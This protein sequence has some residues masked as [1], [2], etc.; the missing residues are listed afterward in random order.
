MLRM[1]DAAAAQSRAD[2]YRLSVTPMRV[3]TKPGSGRGELTQS[4]SCLSNCPPVVSAP[5]T[6]VPGFETCGDS[7]CRSEVAGDVLTILRFG[8][9]GADFGDDAVDGLGAE[10]R[11]GRSVIDQGHVRE[12]DG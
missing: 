6:V 5:Q 2:R 11:R 7:F 12:L 1:L 10:V 4:A 3:G 9:L 8:L